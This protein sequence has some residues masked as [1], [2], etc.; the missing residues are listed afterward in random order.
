MTSTFDE[1]PS[2]QKALWSAVSGRSYRPDIDGLRAV[3]VTGVVLTHSGLAFPSGGFTGVDIFF[4]ISGF[5]IG[6]HIFSEIAS[7]SFTFTRFY[8]RRAKRILPALFVVLLA[9]LT[10]GLFWLSPAELKMDA[11]S[12]V[13]AVL[14]AS[15]LYFWHFASGYFNRGSTYQPLLMTWSLGVEEQ[16]YLVIPV[17]MLLLARSRRRLVFPAILIVCMLSFFLSVF[18]VG[19]FP[20]NAFYLLPERAWELGIGVALAVYQSIGKPRDLPGGVKSALG[21]CAILLIIAPMFLLHSY[22]T[23]PGPAALP[24]VLGTAIAIALPAAWTNRRILSFPPLVFIGKISY[25]W[26]LWHWPLLAFLRL[27]CG[28]QLTL[29]ASCAAIMG[30][31]LLAILSFYC[32]EQPFRNS[33]RPSGPLLIRYAAVSIVI[34]GIFSCVWATGGFRSRYPIL[35]RMDHQIAEVEAQPCL[36]SALHPV[37]SP[38]CFPSPGVPKAVALWGDSHGAS[39]APGFRSIANGQ[40]FR[41]IE[42]AHSGCAP[43]IGVANYRPQNPLGWRECLAFNR[44]AISLLQQ[45]HSIGLVILAARWS[46]FFSDSAEADGFVDGV[47][48][49]RVPFSRDVANQLLKRSLG[50][51]VNILKAAGKTVII[52]DDVPNFSFDPVMRVRDSRIAARHYVAKLLGS[53]NATDPGF[54]VPITEYAAV[55]TAA[56]KQ[57][58]SLN[59][60]LDFIQMDSSLCGQPEQCSYREGDV[61]LYSDGQ[62]LTPEGAQYALRNFH[63]ADAN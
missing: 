7:G 23:F 13:A 9:T 22:S 17:L 57:F 44:E 55:T 52:V 18:E 36:V 46:D 59:P 16:F 20:R 38:I 51:T 2:A 35:V 12:S 1:R 10:I 61:L 24:S 14:S 39:L 56:L 50:E 53:P 6:S 63:F 15:N 8:Q 28:D 47:T 37:R 48:S 11:A 19:R 21:W 54:A 42:I 29:A 58:V 43:T 33:K 41:M 49:G 60:G 27:A 26:Y 34:V 30:S 40:G 62:H 3:A 31:L 5:L 4:V 45:D 32:I 25:S